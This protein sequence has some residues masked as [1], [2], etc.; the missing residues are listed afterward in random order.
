[1]GVVDDRHGRAVAATAAPAHACLE[2]GRPY[3]RIAFFLACYDRYLKGVDERGER[4]A[5]NEPNARH[6]LDKVIESDSPMTLL[7]VTEIVYQP[8]GPDI[9]RE[10][11]AFAAMAGR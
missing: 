1:M 4:Y 5:L 9:A 11:T 8:T 2:H 7:G 10:L 6:L 3:H